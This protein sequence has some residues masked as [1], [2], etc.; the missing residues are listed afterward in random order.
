MWTVVSCKF[1]HG[2]LDPHIADSC[3]CYNGGSCAGSGACRC[4]PGWTGN[5]CEYGKMC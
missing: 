1:S 4:K 3:G 2:V 5:R